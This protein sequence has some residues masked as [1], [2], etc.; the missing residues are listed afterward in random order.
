[1]RIEP[2]DWL[3]ICRAAEPAAGVSLFKIS[4]LPASSAKKKSQTKRLRRAPASLIDAGPHRK[5]SSFQQFMELRG[6]PGQPC[7][8]INQ[9][10]FLAQISAP[11][12]I[13]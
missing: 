1:M 13:L 5:H 7:P 4:W 12:R 8:G 3:S 2:A 6:A 11:H 10:I 9:D